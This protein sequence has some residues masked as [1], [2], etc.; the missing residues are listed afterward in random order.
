MN[1][2]FK[3]FGVCVLKTQRCIISKI[4]I[5]F[6]REPIIYEV[7]N[8]F[9]AFVVSVCIGGIN[10]FERCIFCSNTHNENPIRAT[11]IATIIWSQWFGFILPILQSVMG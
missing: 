3:F 9:N 5:I 6:E 10:R 11:I 8:G 7:S 4:S 2:L 1:R